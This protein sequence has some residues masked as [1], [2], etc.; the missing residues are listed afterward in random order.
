MKEKFESLVEHL[1]TN[2]FFLEEA[3]EILEKTLIQR[4]LERTRGNR[5]AAAKLL[6]IHRN[7]LQRKLEE[8][9]LVAR[10]V[11]RLPRKPPGSAGSRVKRRKA[12]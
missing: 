3:I 7:T 4:G 6:G 11:R 8:Y 9:Q 2:N 1:I 12:V 10:R 5:S